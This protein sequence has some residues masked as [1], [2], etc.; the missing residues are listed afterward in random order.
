MNFTI[1]YGRDFIQIDV[2]EAA[3]QSCVKQNVM[4][5]PPGDEARINL[6]TDPL[7]GTS[8]RLYIM[9]TVTKETYVCEEMDEVFI[10]MNKDKL[11]T[12]YVPEEIRNIFTNTETPE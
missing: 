6:F 7:V 10:D 3:L 9:N 8:K 2:T 11:Y 12:K 5:I 1:N 4:Y